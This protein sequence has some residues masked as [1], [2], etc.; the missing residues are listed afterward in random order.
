VPRELR[1]RCFEE[2][3]QVQDLRDRKICRLLRCEG[4]RGFTL[5]ELLVVIAIIAIL[6]ALL[7]PTLQ[8]AKSKAN[9]I[10]CLNNERQISLALQMYPSDNNERLPSNGYGNPDSGMKLWVGG[11][12]HWNPS[13]FTNVSFLIDP[14]Y[15]QF[16]DYLRNPAVYRCPSDRSQVQIGEVKYPKVRSYAL[17]GFVNW[18]AP[19]ANNIHPAYQKFIKQNDLSRVNSAGIFTFIDVAPGFVCHA[20]FVVV[21]ESSLYYHMPAAQHDQGC[22]IAYADGHSEYQRWREPQTIEEATQLE[23]INH[24]LYF[25]SNNRDLRWLQEHASKI[26][27]G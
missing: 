7:L 1:L 21:E 15:A 25:R 17:N 11:D 14:K 6:A 9:R 22:T 12:G 19:E 10:A 24:H 16:A 27:S 3:E 20:A 13:S 18:V 8:R 26:K 5:I 23:W 2:I 4:G